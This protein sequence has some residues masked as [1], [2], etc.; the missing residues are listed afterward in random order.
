MTSAADGERIHAEATVTV[1]SSETEP[2]DRWEGT[3]LIETRIVETFTGD[4]EGES[5]VRARGLR[6]EDESA[7]LVSLQRVVGMLGGR[8]GSFVLCGDETIAGGKIAAS[9]FVVQG[10]GTGDLRGLRG[11]GGFTGA[12]GKGS[13]ATLDYWFE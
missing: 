3:T 7:C 8:A 9:W 11:E 13:R 10:S 2:Y 1:K 12:F 5:T 6:R 4:I